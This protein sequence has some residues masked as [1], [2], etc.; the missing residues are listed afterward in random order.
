LNVHQS[1]E[2]TPDVIVPDWKYCKNYHFQNFQLHICKL[3]QAVNIPR[4]FKNNCTNVS[5]CAN[6]EEY[7]S[8]I[9]ICLLEATNQCVP[10][11]R[12]KS[13]YVGV[14]GW[15]DF[16]DEKHEAAR[17]AFLEWMVNGKP[18]SDHIYEIMKITRAKFKLALRYYKTNEER[19][20]CDALARDHLS[21]NGNFW[22]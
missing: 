12:V 13:S 7:Y 6:I 21:N 18:R 3:L 15:N 20:Q 4:C 22:K 14:A 16:V 1:V 8:K 2:C 17:A 10:S 19:F 9:I 5:H 11:K